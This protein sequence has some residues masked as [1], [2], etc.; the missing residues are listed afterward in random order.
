M[1]EVVFCGVAWGCWALVRKRV[2][3]SD[4]VVWLRVNGWPGLKTCKRCDVSKQQKQKN[5]QRGGMCERCLLLTKE[6]ACCVECG[7]RL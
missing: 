5:E 2:L 7:G 6:L 1:C 4:V 3:D